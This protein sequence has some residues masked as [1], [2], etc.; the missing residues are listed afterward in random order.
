MTEKLLDMGLEE[1]ARIE[2]NAVPQLYALD[3]HKLIRSLETLSLIE[4]A[5]IKLNAIKARKLTDPILSVSRLDYP[6]SN[7]EELKFYL[8]MCD[9]DGQP[10]FGKLPLKYWGDMKYNYEAHNRDYTGVFKD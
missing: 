8:T 2:K 10:D 4:H 9:K 6:E 1:I 5:K 7:P 3:P